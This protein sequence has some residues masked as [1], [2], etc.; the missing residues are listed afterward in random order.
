MQETKPRP[1]ARPGA[2]SSGRPV[3][4]VVCPERGDCRKDEILDR[5]AE[6]GFPVLVGKEPK[7]DFLRARPEADPERI[8]RLEV[9]PRALKALTSS[10]SKKIFLA[11]LHSD[12]PPVIDDVTVLK[13]YSPNKKNLLP[14]EAFR[15][16]VEWLA[17]EFAAR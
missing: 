14:A 3:L 2:P 8:G 11:T 15:D 4:V 6:R 17:G 13:V 16:A 5:A 12:A 1:S 10:P 9:T 7:A